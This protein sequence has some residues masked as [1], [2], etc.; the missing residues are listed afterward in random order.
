M[1]H[2]TESTTATV[3]PKV[4]SA[5]VRYQ[6]TDVDRAVRFYVE[7]LGFA[8]ELHAGAAFAAVS[9]GDLRLLL[10]GPSS[11]GARAM[12]DGR[13]QGAGGWNRI[14]LYVDDLAAIV[15]RLR[16]VGTTFRNDLERGP[17]GAQIQIEDPDGNP[18]ELHEAPAES[19]VSL[20]HLVAPTA[21]LLG[22][23]GLAS[24]AAAQG[25]IATG[26]GRAGA[27][28][29]ALV[30]LVG[31]VVGGLALRRSA[32]RLGAGN[33]RD[34]A[35]VALVV[36]VMGMALAVIH[37]VTSTGGIGTGNGRGGAIVALVLGLIGV[38]LGWMAL[39][40][41]RRAEPASD[42]RSERPLG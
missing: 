3:R 1:S 23:F 22:A 11:S 10:S 35:I 5:V 15:A 32:R 30:A 6:V 29:A 33:G 21:A 28:V 24:P 34:G 31:V 25:V 37:L 42:R 13:A 9:R 7:R 39:N 4:T 14:V 18:V 27:T 40:R 36:G 41:S 16:A 12:P 20:P 8:L 2:A 38:V 19:S 26:S 17:G